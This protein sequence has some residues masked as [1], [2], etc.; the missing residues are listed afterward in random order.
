MV[1]GKESA[2]LIELIFCKVAFG[3]Y[4]HS[5]A[6]LVKYEEVIGFLKPCD[7]TPSEFLVIHF[8]FDLDTLIAAHH[9]CVPTKTRFSETTLDGQPLINPKQNW[10]KGCCRNQAAGETLEKPPMQQAKYSQ[11]SKEHGTE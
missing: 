4:L 9:S 1:L 11:N 8:V 10:D 2:E 3:Y 7:F 6:A 5:P